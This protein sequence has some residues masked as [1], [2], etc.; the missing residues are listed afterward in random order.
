MEVKIEAE[1]GRRM[2]SIPALAQQPIVQATELENTTRFELN[3]EITQKSE[4]LEEVE[5]R[6]ASHRTLA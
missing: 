6:R 3:S 5:E 2:A 4:L 1:L